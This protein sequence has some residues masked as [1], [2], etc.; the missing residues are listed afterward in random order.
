M[1]NNTFVNNHPGI[2][3]RPVWAEFQAHDSQ[4]LSVDLGW[5]VDT[6]GARNRNANS[7]I[8]R[9]RR[10]S[11]RAVSKKEDVKSAMNARVARWLPR[12]V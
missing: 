7:L 8:G 6:F 3:I 9:R 4:R 1:L 11:K 10:K 5:L 12:I 2:H